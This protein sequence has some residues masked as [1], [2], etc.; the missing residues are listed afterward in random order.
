LPLSS[1]AFAQGINFYKFA[2]ENKK[3]SQFCHQ[4]LPIFVKTTNLAKAL[5][6]R[7]YKEAFPFVVRNL[8]ISSLRGHYL[9]NSEEG[10][11]KILDQFTYGEV[12]NKLK[13]I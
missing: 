2:I 12:K 6:T 13:Y 5:L 10:E 3:D 7:A 11:R 4:R 1:Q 9:E 8:S